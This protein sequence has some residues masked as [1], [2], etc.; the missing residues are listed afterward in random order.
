MLIR[1]GKMSV[2]VLGFGMWVAPLLTLRLDVVVV[3]A[4]LIRVTVIS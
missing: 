2:Y 4:Q 3:M 1:K